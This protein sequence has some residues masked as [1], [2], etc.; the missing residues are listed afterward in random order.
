MMQYQWNMIPCKAYERKNDEKNEQ[1][2]AYICTWSNNCTFRSVT[3]GYDK[4]MQDWFGHYGDR[5][6]F[7]LSERGGPAGASFHVGLNIDS[8]AVLTQCNDWGYIWFN[9]LVTVTPSRFITPL[10]IV[11]NRFRVF[12][13]HGH[14]AVILCC[15]HIV[16]ILRVQCRPVATRKKPKFSL[17]LERANDSN[18]S[19]RTLTINKLQTERSQG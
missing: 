5:S 14:V 4:Q 2:N 12:K 6:L 15:V 3:L 9:R 11:R 19:M 17:H 1:F 8:K 10:R 7:V 13:L 18:Y 16:H